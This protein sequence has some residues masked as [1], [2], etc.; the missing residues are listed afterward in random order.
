[1]VDTKWG[2][3]SQEQWAETIG[4]SQRDS[5][6]K[7][8]KSIKDDFLTALKTISEAIDNHREA[9]DQKGH[10]TLTEEDHR[11]GG[12][13]RETQRTW[14]RGYLEKYPNMVFRTHLTLQ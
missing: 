4:V 11:Y 6:S 13:L 2:K 9:L 8:S 12:Y 14:A 10:D 3:L 7:I 1:M 5:R